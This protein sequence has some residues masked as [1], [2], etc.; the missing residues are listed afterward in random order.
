M[1]SSQTTQAAQNSGKTASPFD[2]IRELERR[3]KERVEIELSAMQKEKTEVTLSVAKKEEQATEEMKAAAKKELKAYS[4]TEL[5]SIVAAAKN[6]AKTE[7]E[8]LEARYKEK[9]S[10]AVKMLVEKAKD[11]ENL[12]HTAA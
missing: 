10:A 5:T 1:N 7:C 11:P 6:E 4:E 12:F 8:Q 3:E 9:K 2:Q